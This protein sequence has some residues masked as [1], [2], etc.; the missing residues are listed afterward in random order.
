[1]IK[2][3]AII[4]TI[5]ILT[6]TACSKEENGDTEEPLAYESLT[7]VKT[8]LKPGETT[9]IKAVATGSNLKYIWTATQ[10]DI[11]GSGAEVTYA[12]SICHVGT[13]QVSC[14]VTGGKN[15]SGKKTI[16]IHVVDE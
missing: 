10:G 4:F 9:R 16:Q 6:A 7:A 2:K 14:E 12:P 8:T 1:M 15:Q 3:I 13:N 11:L 5:L